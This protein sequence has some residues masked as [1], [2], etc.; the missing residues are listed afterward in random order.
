MNLT[1][2]VFLTCLLSSNIF[3]QSK[4][5]EI[6]FVIKLLLFQESPTSGIEMNKELLADFLQMDVDWDTLKSENFDDYI[7]LSVSPTLKNP[8]NLSVEHFPIVPDNCKEYVVALSKDIGAFYRLKGFKINDFPSFIADLRDDQ[9]FK[10][11]SY[12][13]FKKHFHVDNLD[14]GCLYK[15]FKDYGRDTEKYPCLSRCRDLMSTH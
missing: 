9:Y 8:N 1:L 15:A 3:G 13:S 7:F 2:T 4:H 12:K 14:L 11:E 10:L 6:S 5:A